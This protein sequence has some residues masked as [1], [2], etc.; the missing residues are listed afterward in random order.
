MT[1]LYVINVSCSFTYCYHSV[2]V[3]SLS[4][5]Q[6]DHIKQLPQC[7]QLTGHKLNEIVLTA[8]HLPNKNRYSSLAFFINFG[9]VR[10]FFKVKKSIQFENQFIDQDSKWS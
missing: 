4:L 2:S 9:K 6:S 10:C 3:I 1:I 8:K 7:L 5:S